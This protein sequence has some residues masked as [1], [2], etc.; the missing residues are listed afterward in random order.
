MKFPRILS[1]FSGQVLLLDGTQAV[2]DS[3]ERHEKGETKEE[4]VPAADGK[5]TPNRESPGGAAFPQ[6][7]RYLYLPCYRTGSQ[8]GETNVRGAD[9]LEIAGSLV[10]SIPN[11][12]SG[13]PSCSPGA[14]SHWEFVLPQAIEVSEEGDLN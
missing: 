3:S 2:L 4:S 9:G 10:R 12:R 8:A 11:D 13:E 7:M 6:R 5:E 1:S 14:W